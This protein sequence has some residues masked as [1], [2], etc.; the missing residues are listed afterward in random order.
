MRCANPVCVPSLQIFN[1]R[2]GT[3]NSGLRDFL[4]AVFVSCHIVSHRM[5]HRIWSKW[6][7]LFCSLERIQGWFKPYLFIWCLE[8]FANQ[9]SSLRFWGFILASPYCCELTGKTPIKYPDVLDSI[10]KFSYIFSSW[11]FWRPVGPGGPGGPALCY[12]EVKCQR[13]TARICRSAFIF[14]PDFNNQW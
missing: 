14:W 9:L 6:T 2:S 4:G 12:A 11:D 7:R 10:I 1:S 8:T 13:H 3:W 5:T